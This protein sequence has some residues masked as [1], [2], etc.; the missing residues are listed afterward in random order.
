[1]V[2]RDDHKDPLT[3]EEVRGIVAAAGSVGAVLNRRVARERG[4]TEPDV[5]T[6]GAAVLE[7]SNGLLR[8]VLV[9]LGRAVVGTHQAEW[10]ALLAR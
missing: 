1:M 7:D 6:F 8:R 2:D 3:A 10:R 4:R 9:G 5:E